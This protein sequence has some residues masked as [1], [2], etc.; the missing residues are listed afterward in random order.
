MTTYSQVR[1]LRPISTRKYCD[2]STRGAAEAKA[3]LIRLIKVISRFEGLDPRA[4]VTYTN[5]VNGTKKDTNTVGGHRDYFDTE[6]PG[7]VMYD[8]LAEVRAAAARR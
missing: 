3:S 4:R 7:Q 1:V 8:L 2:R 6:C 5:P